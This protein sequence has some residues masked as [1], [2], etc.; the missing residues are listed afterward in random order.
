MWTIT[1]VTDEQ[2][3]LERYVKLALSVTPPS[4][5]SKRQKLGATFVQWFETEPGVAFVDARGGS[6]DDRILATKYVRSMLSGHGY[7]VAQYEVDYASMTKDSK[8]S[9]IMAKA[10]RLIQ[11][12]KVQLLRN[13]AEN[14][15]AMVQ[16][17]HGT[18]QSEFSRDDPNSEA[19]TQWQCD[20][21][22]DQYAWQRTR[23][24]KKYEGRPCAHVLAAWWKSQ[25]TPVDE[26]IHPANQMQMNMGQPQ[27]PQPLSPFGQQ[28]PTAPQNQPNPFDQGQQMM[29]PGMAQPGMA[30][31]TPPISGMPPE[32]LPPFPYEQEV[33]G[34]MPPPTP[35]SIPGA[36]PQTPMNPVQWPG[37]TYSST[38][39]EPAFGMFKQSEWQNGAMVQLLGSEMGVAEGPDPS[40]AMHG[41]YMEIKPNSVGE[42]MGVDNVPGLGQTVEVIFPLHN[43]GELEPYHVRAWLRPEQ[44]RPRPDIK[45]PGPFIRRKR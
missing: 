12:N 8:W 9:D 44:L 17:D 33:S 37:G 14:V 39:W 23:Q 43:T 22:W 6:V 30:Q 21:P 26:D 28:G 3:W 15:V 34:E 10:K 19:M 24:W 27:V 29:L 35:V 13:G 38:E 11:T 1:K 7:R 42:V 45:Q 41:S 20:C 31:G 40:N 36:K 2:D 25:A 18:Y 16:G 32:V 4:L 5:P